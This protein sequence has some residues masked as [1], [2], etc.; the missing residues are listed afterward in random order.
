MNAAREQAERAA[1]RI[2]SELLVT[3]QE[4][5]RRRH[6]AFDLKYQAEKHFTLVVV[7]AGC[8]AAAA[9]MAVAISLTRARTHR[10]SLLGARLRELM[11]AWE[12]P[13][14]A[15]RSAA[16]GVSAAAARK[17]VT[18]LAVTLATQFARRS[19]QRLLPSTFSR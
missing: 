3:L 11:R 17:L 18:V 19:A 9:G 4:L 10:E 15:A 14:P 13:H 1:D 5:D 12:A 16:P 7:V 2:R 8:A 6:R